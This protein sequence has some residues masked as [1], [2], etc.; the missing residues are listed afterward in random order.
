MSKDD[1]P[2][3]TAPGAGMSNGQEIIAKTGTTNTAQSAFFIGAI[4]SQAMAVALFTDLQGDKTAKA[5]SQTLNGLGGNSQGGFGGTWPAAIWHT[6]AEDMFVPLGVEQFPRRSSPAPPG[7]RCRRTCATS[8][9][10]QEARPRPE[11]QRPERQRQRQ[12][13]PQPLPHLRLR[14]D[15]RDLPACQRRRRSR[16]GRRRWQLRPGRRSARGRGRGSSRDRPPPLGPPSRPANSSSVSQRA[17]R[18]RVHKKARLDMGVDVPESAN[19][20]FGGGAERPARPAGLAAA[21]GSTSV[22]VVA[23]VLGMVLAFAEKFPCR[24]G[25]WNSTPASSSGPATPTSTRCTTARGFP[26]K[27]SLHRPP[28]RVPG[29]DRRGHAG[30]GRSG[31]ERQ[32]GD[33]GPRV[34]RCH[35][36]AA[37]GLRGGD[38]A[39]DRARGRVKGSGGGHRR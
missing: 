13:E 31:A 35:R 22:L 10:A 39:G 2:Y 12:R 4:P 3:G 17:A 9:E 19:A 33:Q 7:T 14:P 29:A 23:S 32:R 15:R 11:R 37:R 1:A 16:A 34:L 21:L 30:R 25:A 36:G 5:R 18:R 6:Y 8:K 27:G 24:S 20:R 26:R 28:G 38:R